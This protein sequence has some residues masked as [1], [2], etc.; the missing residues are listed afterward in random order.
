M[1][2][3]S[4]FAGD[5]EGQSIRVTEDGRFS[6]YDVLVAFGITDKAHAQETL[7][8]AQDK[9]SEVV[10]SCSYFK[11]PGRGQ[12]ETPVA[13]WG[14]CEQI[15]MI[16]GKHPSQTAVTSEKFYPRA[17]TQIVS[18]L[19]ESFQDL[20]PV[21]QFRVH[22]YRIDLYLAAANIAI[23]IDEY[24][25]SDYKSEEELV[26]SKAIKSA[27]GC[28]FVRIDPYAADFNLGQVIRQVRDLL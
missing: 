15:L 23:E 7:K 8:R 13:D 18:V 5:Y 2:N 9:Y 14:I 6:I 10:Q 21:P 11:F 19:M 27:L 16:L 4:V 28:S 24:D 12:R 3:L 26:R 25:H 20:S 1:T 17:E 22:G